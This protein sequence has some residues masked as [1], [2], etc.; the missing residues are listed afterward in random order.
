MYLCEM[1]VKSQWAV[2][3][4]IRYRAQGIQINMGALVFMVWR[5]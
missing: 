5:L 1:P 4:V 3:A 2:W